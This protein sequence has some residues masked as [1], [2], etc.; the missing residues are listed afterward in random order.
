MKR[1][2]QIFIIFSIFSCNK[3]NIDTK[4]IEKS[5]KDS[6]LAIK[7]KEDSIII[8]N[9][10]TI[11]EVSVGDKTIKLI[12]KPKVS[13]EVEFENE[14]LSSTTFYSRKIAER[15]NVLINFQFKLTSKSKSNTNNFFPNLNVFIIDKE[16]SNIK[17]INE[18]HYQLLN[19]TD[20]PIS[21]LE[22]IFDYQE[23][24][25]FVGWVEVEEKLLNKIVISVNKGGNRKLMKE[26]IVA[27]FIK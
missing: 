4:K 22:Q 16:K 17:H 27:N 19:K 8:S 7:K 1:L 15:N 2:F 18:M 6:L 25:I 3:S 14:Y 12:S 5:K 9:I 11:K 13:K 23:S 26:N 24:A 21:Y 10:S 20:K